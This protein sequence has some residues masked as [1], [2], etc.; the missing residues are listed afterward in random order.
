M[1]NLSLENLIDQSELNPETIEID[2]NRTYGGERTD[3]ARSIIRTWEGGLALGGFT[4]SYGSGRADMWLVKTTENGMVQRSKTYGTADIE[5]ANTMIQTND[6]GYVLA[7]L[8]KPDASSREDLW[9]VKTDFGG[10]MQWNLTFGDI[11]DEGANDLL[12]TA[13]GD[14]LI[15]GYQYW[16]FLLLKVDSAGN[17]VWNKT[18]GATNTDQR[19][20]CIIKTSDG[21]F[22]FTGTSVQYGTDFRDAWFVKTDVDGI[23]QLNRSYGGVEVESALTLIE[24]E[25]NGF[26]LAGSIASSYNSPTDLWI[27]KID[28]NGSEQW[29]HTY[30]GSGNERALDIV[31][32][33]DGG[34]FISGITDSYGAGQVDMWLLNI[35]EFGNLQWNI[36]FGGSK[37]DITSAIIQAE[38]KS[39][40]LAG[41]TRSFGAQ[42]GDSDMWLVK[43]DITREE[44]E[45]THFLFSSL[46][47]LGLSVGS[48][49]L[50]LIQR[51]K[52]A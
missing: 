37:T 19:A 29:N 45:S 8:T 22:A 4:W 50:L 48:V 6:R 10:M 40:L 39:L 7:G 35:D 5:E 12:Q 20:Y 34:Y 26:I 51:K 24:T 17:L 30:G 2:F 33:D 44:E 49:V 18:Y 46:L 15:V 27:M 28:F 13:E 43:I 1:T 23:P 16:D 9:I 52:F 3:E 41:S 31:Q 36:T 38:D 21:G 14:Y 25:D 42:L 47:F 32:N 11:G